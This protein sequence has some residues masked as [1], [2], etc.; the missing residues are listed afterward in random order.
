MTTSRFLD[1]RKFEEKQP[2]EKPALLLFTGEGGLRDMTGVI[3]T[4]QETHLEYTKNSRGGQ[5]RR[6]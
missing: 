5:R 3:S 6:G 1:F 2:N 4:R